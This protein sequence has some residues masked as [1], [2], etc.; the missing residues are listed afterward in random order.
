[1]ARLK[2]KE[3]GPPQN[4]AA[5]L[6]NLMP[7]VS[8]TPEQEEVFLPGVTRIQALADRKLI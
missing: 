2:Y 3:R 8:A 6:G 7:G 1:M 5:H 4:R